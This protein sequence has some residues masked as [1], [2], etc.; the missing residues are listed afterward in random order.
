MP[1]PVGIFPDNENEALNFRLWLGMLLP[2]LAGGINTVVGYMV[3]N[4]DC[5]V[6]NRR[7]VFLV[8]VLAAL[9]C[10]AGGLISYS[11]RSTIEARLDDASESLLHSRRFMM[12]VGLS[13]AAGFFIFIC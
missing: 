8:N 11:T 2:P 10:I 3:S 7:L 4:Y 12:W 5:N 9:V 13:F 6:Q 1:T